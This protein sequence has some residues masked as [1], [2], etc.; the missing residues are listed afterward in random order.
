MGS[1]EAGGE[2]GETPS[3]ILAFTMISL[4][5]VLSLTHTLE[6]NTLT[7]THHGECARVFHTV[8]WNEW[9]NIAL[10]GLYTKVVF[11]C[12]KGQSHEIFMAFLYFYPI[13]EKVLTFCIIFIFYFNHVFM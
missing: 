4:R 11:I 2:G 12:L 8:D 6:T 9:L 10:M 3:E 7:P 13:V 1:G 5:N